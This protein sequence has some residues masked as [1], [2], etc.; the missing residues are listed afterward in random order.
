MIGMGM[1]DQ[2]ALDRADRV[3]EEIAKRAIKAFGARVQN[4]FGADHLG[5]PLRLTDGGGIILG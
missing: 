4:L 2:G 5:V 3:D 1:G